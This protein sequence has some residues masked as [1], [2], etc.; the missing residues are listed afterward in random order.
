M[1]YK[2]NLL[3]KFVRMK[4]L[5]LLA[6]FL[7]GAFAV[8]AQLLDSL[9]A[10][11]K[12]KKHID[13]RLESRNSFIANDR[14]LIS[15]VR[16]GVACERKLKFGL[17]VS[18]LSSNIT[19]E[20]TIINDLNKTDIVKSYLKLAYI[21]L[22]ADFVFHK[23]KRW[24]LSIPIQTGMGASWLQRN[25]AYNLSTS[26]KNFLLLYEPGISTQF[27]I[28]KWFGLGVDIGYRFTLKNDAF[29]GN[30]LNSP[31]YAF[32]LQFWADELFYDLFPKSRITQRFGPAQW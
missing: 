12:K 21:C 16:V 26:G 25:M 2:Q 19:E 28:F 14:A 24:Q 9:Q 32:K 27:K 18:W 22:Y 23:T 4:K 13:L 7:A 17:G 6:M 5:F 3:F 20:Q 31:T 1:I 15:G 30:R 29:V 11:L 8:Q 10:M